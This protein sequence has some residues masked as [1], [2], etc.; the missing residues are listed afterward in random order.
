[1]MQAMDAKSETLVPIQDLVKTTTERLEADFSRV[2]TRIHKFTPGL[3]GVGGPGN[4]YILPT[5]VALGPYHHGLTHL[6]EA[7][8]VKH[9]GASYFS[10]QSGHSVEEVYGKMLSIAS[11]ARGC[12]KDNVVAC[13]N[14]AEFAA[15]MFLDGCFLL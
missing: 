5:F 15:M 3:P 2:G 14:K 11:E 6:Q 10:A 4:S 12:Y 7:C 13:F 8:V 1:M 9:A